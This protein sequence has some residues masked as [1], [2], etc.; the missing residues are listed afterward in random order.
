ML[1][2]IL[3]KETAIK[4]NEEELLTDT[5]ETVSSTISAGKLPVV[6][7]PRKDI[8][9]ATSLKETWDII[10]DVN[11]TQMEPEADCQITAEI[12][13][14]FDVHSNKIKLIAKM[15]ACE[16]ARDSHT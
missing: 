4:V 16:T 13:V 8:V 3:N 15:P 9:N 6:A 5:C 11:I 1:M 7:I 14:Y 2:D 12:P 10:S